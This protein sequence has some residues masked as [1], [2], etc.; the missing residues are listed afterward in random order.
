MAQLETFFVMIG[1]AATSFLTHRGVLPAPISATVGVMAFGHL[2]GMMGAYQM[3]PASVRW[4][5]YIAKKPR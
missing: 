1:A 3:L 5:T 4:R 2:V